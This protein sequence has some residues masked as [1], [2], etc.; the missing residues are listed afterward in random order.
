MQAH[1][2]WPALRPK[3]SAVVTIG[4]YDGVHRGHQS[5]LAEVVRQAR[6]RDAEA[7]VVTFEPHPRCVLDPERCPAQL[8]SIDEKLLLLERAGID[9][10]VVVEFTPAVARLTPQQFMAALTRTMTVK[11]MVEGSDFAFG[12]NRAGDRR[13]LVRYGAQRGF[14]VTRVPAYRRGGE[15]VSSSTIRR[16]LLRGQVAPANRFLGY[17]YF[18]Q[19]F[20]EHGAKVGTRIGYPT[21]NLTITP[22]KLIPLGGVYAVRVAMGGTTYAG[23]LN[24]GYRPTFGGDKLTVE[25]FILDFAGEIYH[26]VL[27]VAFVAR[28]RD[29][30]KFA[31]VEALIRQ[32]GRDVERARQALRPRS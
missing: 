22:N 4:T 16:L 7:V 28:L 5:V 11:H 14:H 8:S 21:A 29:E 18:I 32:I 23:A 19:S 24:V 12:R 3:P 31:S 25:A 2:G 15:I 17:E 13:F 30:K 26:Q 1:F 9:R 6:A 10:T 27:R 20:V